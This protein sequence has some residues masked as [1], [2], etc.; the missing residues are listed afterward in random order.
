MTVSRYKS[1]PDYAE[2]YEA[3]MRRE[4][5]PDDASLAFV[6]GHA[7]AREAILVLERFGFDETAPGKFS[8]TFSL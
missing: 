4:A 2:G 3:S 5:C 7:A 1:D 6:A 8:K